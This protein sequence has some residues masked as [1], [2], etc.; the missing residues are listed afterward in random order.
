M[1]SVAGLMLL[2]LNEINASC[3]SSV[4]LAWGL[5]VMPSW[6]TGH[7]CFIV[8]S[9]TLSP[10]FP[11]P[12]VRIH[13]SGSFLPFFLFVES[14]HYFSGLIL[15][16][17]LLI[18]RNILLNFLF[19]PEAS[20]HSDS[21]IPQVILETKEW[22]A[23]RAICYGRRPLKGP[24]ICRRGGGKECALE[25]MSLGVRNLWLNWFHL[26]AWPQTQM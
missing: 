17:P 25:T 15:R 12:L 11:L 7:C 10:S 2:K 16:S 3:F 13:F 22:E 20:F 5:Q 26:H 18:L 21:R 19:K 9:A 24:R 14:I 4:L 6:P 23:V 8:S 1:Y